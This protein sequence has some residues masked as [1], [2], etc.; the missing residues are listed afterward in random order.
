MKL[1]SL[2]GAGILSLAIASTAIASDEMFQNGRGEFSDSRWSIYVECGVEG[3]YV[4]NGDRL[5]TLPGSP[6]VTYENGK[7]ISTWSKAGTKYQAIWNAKDPNFV[8]LKVISS[9]GQL[10]TDRLL[11]VGKE[12]PC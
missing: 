8:R 1:L 9:Q 12:P 6:R 2:F 11:K 7:K 10:L 4:K 5:L 3:L